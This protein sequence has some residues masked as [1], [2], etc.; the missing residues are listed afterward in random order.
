VSAG[1]LVVALTALLCADAFR[2]A[3]YAATVYLYVVAD[4]SPVLE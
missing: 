3:S 2:A 1:A 4:E